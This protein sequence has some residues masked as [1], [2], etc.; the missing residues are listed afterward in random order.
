MFFYA[1]FFILALGALNRVRG[2]D[3]WMRFGHTEEGAKFLPGRP[4]FYVAPLLGLLSIPFVGAQN[5]FVV[6]MAYTFWAIWP[7]GRWFDLGRLPAPGDERQ[8][9]F[10]EETI[11][12]LTTS[13]H[14]ALFLRHLAILPFLLLLGVKA[15]FLGIVFAALAVAVY[16]AAWRARPKNPIWVAEVGVGLLWAVLILL[17]GG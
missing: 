17:L 9:D 13:D 6:A 2:D 12:R 16:E 5:A 4:L 8:A 7:W 10:F 14:W 3:R 1:L 11:E 15:F